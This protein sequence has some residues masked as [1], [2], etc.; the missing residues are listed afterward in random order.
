MIIHN[1]SDEATRTYIYDT[2][3]EIVIDQPKQVIIQDD[4][5]EHRVTTYSHGNYLVKPG[6]VCVRWIN[7]EG[8]N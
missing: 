7:K 1:V 8:I 4:P 6:W 2:G 5:D 3:L